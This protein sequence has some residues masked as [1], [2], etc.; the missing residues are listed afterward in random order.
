MLTILANASFT[1]LG[2]FARTSR[3]NRALVANT[4]VLWAGL[5][6]KT[7]GSLG[8]VPVA[9]LSSNDWRQRFSAMLAEYR[10]L[11]TQT[12][13]NNKQKRLDNAL[14]NIKCV[15]RAFIACFIFI[16]ICFLL[17]LFLFVFF[18]K[19]FD[20]NFTFCFYLFYFSLSFLFGY[21][22]ILLLLII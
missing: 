19:K 18:Y 16:L 9:A 12:W 1:T 13:S 21:Q 17:L 11:R 15:L 20:F 10:S 4:N 8:R 7:F 3:A 22:S 6:R 5:Y 14:V 2:R